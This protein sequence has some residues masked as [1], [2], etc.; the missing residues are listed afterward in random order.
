MLSFD[1][2]AYAYRANF[3]VNGVLV[4]WKRLTDVEEE[5]LSEFLAKENQHIPF[6]TILKERQEFW[7][8]NQVDGTPTNFDEIMDN[9]IKEING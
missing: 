7:W 6:E 5:N 8:M 2:E 3:F 9:I 4:D 1:D